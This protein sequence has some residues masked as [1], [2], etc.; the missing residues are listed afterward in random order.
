MQGDVAMRV[1]ADHLRAPSRSQSPTD[2]CRRTSRPAMSSAA[3]CAVPCATAIPTSDSPSRLC[4]PVPGLV[5]QMGGQF[6]ELKASRVDREGHR[7]GGGFVPAHAGYGHQLLDGVIARTKSEGRKAISAPTPSSCTIRS[8]SRSTLRSSSPA[9]RA[10]KSTSMPSTRSCRLRRSVRATPR[11]STRRLGRALPLRE[12][13]FTGYDTL[14]D[15]VRIA[16]YRRVTSQGQD[17]LP[18][19]LRPHA[20]LRQFGRSDRRH[21][22]PSRAPTSV[23][24]W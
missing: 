2:S 10:W 15:E 23:S 4:P 14:T 18:A 6:P 17:F 16:R 3:S 12:S 19:G 22:A 5:G 1:I 7:G 8:D 9:S 11:P 21:Q 24:R 13:V 20:V